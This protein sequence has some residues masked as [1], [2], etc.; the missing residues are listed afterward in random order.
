MV[1]FAL[2]NLNPVLSEK[3]E[4]LVTGT[5]LITIQLGIQP[6]RE[7]KLELKQG[8]VV[9]SEIATWTFDCIHNNDLIDYFKT[10]FEGGLNL[11][12]PGLR[13]FSTADIC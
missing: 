6:K 2:A 8:K 12:V 4:K 3:V 1:D 11:E 9:G 5:Q 13:L 10:M 7:L